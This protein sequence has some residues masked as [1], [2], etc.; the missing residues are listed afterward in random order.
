M[1]L[2]LRGTHLLLLLVPFLESLSDG[3]FVPTTFS[4]FLAFEVQ[5]GYPV[6]ILLLPP[7]LTRFLDIND[8]QFK[9]RLA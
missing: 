7:L 4:N 9:G 3:L 2:L 5:S 1:W 6:N 8:I